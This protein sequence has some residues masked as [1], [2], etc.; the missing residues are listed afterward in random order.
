MTAVPAA[1]QHLSPVYGV[2]P[3]RLQSMNGLWAGLLLHS[4]SL[5]WVFDPDAQQLADTTVLPV[6]AAAA[7]LHLVADPMHGD[8][9]ESQDWTFRLPTP[10]R[11]ARLHRGDSFALG[12]TGKPLKIIPE[13]WSM[14]VMQ[15]ARCR[16]LAAACVAFPEDD[17][18]ATGR[19]IS[20][21][22][23]DGRVVGGTI[24]VIF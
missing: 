8:V 15:G 3:I 12:F 20:E 18:A 10:A 21:A 14:A 7:G 16:L 5:T 13:W 4:R 6:L 17:P 19:I 11:S 22:A 24:A 1:P 23:A 9:P 2:S